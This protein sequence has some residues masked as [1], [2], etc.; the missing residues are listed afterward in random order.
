MKFELRAQDR[1]ALFGLAGALGLYLLISEV[2]LPV[3]DALQSGASSVSQKEDELRKYRRAFASRDHYTQLLAQAKKS[4]AEAEGRLVRG[5]NPSLASVELQTIVEEAA[6]K[7]NITLG[8]RNMTAAKKKD[9]FFNEITMTLSFEGTVNQLTSLL[10]EVRNAPKVLTV[11]TL[12]IAPVNPV[13]EAP[14]KGELKKTVRVTLTVAALL[15]API[16]APKG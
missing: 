6:K 11:K 10:S 4:V 13:Q 1:R 16:V 7:V 3:Y 5:D 2:A 12:Q 14:L 15:A 8:Q 9:E